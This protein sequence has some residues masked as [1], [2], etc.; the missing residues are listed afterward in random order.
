MTPLLMPV[1]RRR[2]LGLRYLGSKSSVN[3]FGSVTTG[4]GNIFSGGLS[5][6]AQSQDIVLLAEANSSSVPPTP[7]GWT[8]L[9]TVSETTQRGSYMR[10][11]Y[12]ILTGSWS[13][14]TL[15]SG[16]DY[17]LS[18]WRGV[19][20]STPIDVTTQTASHAGTVLTDPPSITPITADCIVVVFGHA[21]QG[22]IPSFTSWIGLSDPNVDTGSGGGYGGAIGTAYYDAWSSGAYNPPAWSMTNDGTSRSATS[23][24]IVLRPAT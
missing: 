16:S 6:A 24:T 13:N 20:Q 9:A 23:A 14:L 4:G 2:L 10:V 11:S 1:R 7:S 18:C 3:T 21:A 5:D 8:S 12:K 19:D 22:A 17:S 15:G